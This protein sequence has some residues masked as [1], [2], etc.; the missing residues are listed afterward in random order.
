[1]RDLGFQDVF[2]ELYNKE[3]VKSLH[4]H[5]DPVFDFDVI[6]VLWN[7]ASSF[8]FHLQIMMLVLVEGSK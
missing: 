2:F 3:I 1:M 5:L 6:V 7:L 8:L 4:E